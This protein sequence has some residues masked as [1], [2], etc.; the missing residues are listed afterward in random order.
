MSEIV[1]VVGYPAS[2][3][4]TICQTYEE[5]G[6][7]RINR[8]AVGGTLADLL[9]IIEQH[10]KEGEAKLILDNTYGTKESRKPVVDLAK[11]YGVLPTCLWLTT[12]IED[13][14]FN[15]CMRMM[16]RFGAVLGPEAIKE[17][18]DPNTFPA[19]AL[20]RYRKTLEKPTTDEGFG[21]VQQETFQRV[22][23]PEY[24]NAAYIL[25]YDGCLRETISGDNFPTTPEDIRI[26]PGRK[27]VLQG[28]ADQGALLLGASNQSGV[29]KGLLTA[30]QACAC[31]ERTNELLGVDIKY[32]FCPHRV[33]PISCYCRK[34]M[35]GMGVEF[36]ETH[37]LDPS[38][39]IMVGDMKSDETFAKRCGFQF[40]YADEF[41]AQ[42][43]AE[44]NSK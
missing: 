8:D 23:G 25:D 6:F 21:E 26:L 32:N 12:S 9:P 4:S 41:F 44:S 29:A 40:Q 38:L 15:A 37:K 30:H 22:W 5:K 10:L 13:A 11:R 7:V 24:S 19:A 39:T 1:L 34:P 43:L 18:K 3:K 42:A 31:F 33:P 2:G 35:P 14:Q 36:I 28:L 17:K 16:K 27:E 20:F